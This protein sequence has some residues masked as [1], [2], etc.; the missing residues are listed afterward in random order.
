[1]I[2]K[3]RIDGAIASCTITYSSNLSAFVEASSASTQAATIEQFR[4]R[5]LPVSSLSTFV[6][7]LLPTV[8][9]K[10]H[11]R[12]Q[13]THF[14]DH[15]SRL[16]CLRLWAPV[17]PTWVIALISCLNINQFNQPVLIYAKVAG[18][19]VQCPR[20]IRW[21]LRSLSSRAR[22]EGS[23][24]RGKSARYPVRRPAV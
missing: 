17:A 5:R 7:K 14:C 2:S 22:V 18:F 8:F 11:I 20:L 1:M 21:L 24:R 4:T 23:A 6:A 15:G 19:P 13:S 10:H 12:P 3:D 16:V 9:A